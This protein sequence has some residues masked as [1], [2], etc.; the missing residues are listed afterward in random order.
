MTI[1]VCENPS[2]SVIILI[3]IVGVNI[4]RRRSEC[5][6]RSLRDCTSEYIATGLQPTS[7]EQQ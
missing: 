4:Q 1:G 2:Y 6:A 7:E 5:L 3:V